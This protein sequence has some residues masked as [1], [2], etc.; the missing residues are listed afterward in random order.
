MSIFTSPR[1]KAFTVLLWGDRW[2]LAGR[3][4][5]IPFAH[6]DRAAG[7]LVAA[8]AGDGPR[9]LRLI[10]QPD[11]FTSVV[12]PCPQAGR[13][14]LALALQDQFPG[15]STGEIAWSHDPILPLGE[16]FTTVIH[17]ESSPWLFAVLEQLASAGIVVEEVWPLPT[18]LQALPD[19]WSDSGA[20][21]VLAISGDCACAY[22]HPATGA[23]QVLAWPTNG[24][25][26]PTLWLANLLDRDS[27]EPILV[28]TD[29]ATSDTAWPQGAAR[30]G[31]RHLTLP[32]ALAHS[33]TIPPRHPARL[34]P[35]EPVV[36]AS[37]AVLVASVA[38]LLAT[39]GMAGPWGW[40][41]VK[42][43]QTA[44]VQTER[45]RALSA[46][47]AHLRANAAEIAALREEAAGRTA[48]FAGD[49]LRR[50][51]KT[52][53]PEATL[54]TLRADA[55]SFAAQGFLAPQ[56]SGGVL[57]RWQQALARD[58]EGSQVQVQ[59]LPKRD[60]A[61]YLRGQGKT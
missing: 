8:L 29:A 17:F 18:W 39:G 48:P 33:A 6:R 13:R 16:S 46:E 3:T 38:L 11:G 2:W 36:T 43:R 55:G 10:Y 9:R 44:L 40:A 23:R 53:P 45:E 32:E 52:V 19:E 49:L 22:H 57:D 7:E 20:F 30:P 12:T 61:F 21:T 58:R 47:V 5:A 4:E 25:T 24:P 41:H 54:A 59:S 50:L 1:S 31:L 56:A 15:L 42:A 27:G 37:R 35:A 14:M 26:T 51:A 34:L 60:G 28:V